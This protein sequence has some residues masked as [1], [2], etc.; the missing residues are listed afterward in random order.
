MAPKTIV[1]KAD[2]FPL[3]K[4]GKATAVA[5]TPGYLLQYDSVAGQIEAHSSSGGNAA[6]LFAI[7][8]ALQGKEIGDNY[9][10]S[11]QVQFVCAR[12]GDEIYAMLK[13]GQ[14][15]TRGQYLESNGDGTLIAYSSGFPVAVALEAV[16]LSASAN[17]ADARIKVEIM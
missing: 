5:I 3:Q 16:D 4:L 2:P 15:I 9:A 11:A 8:D 7:E 1:L 10:V 17:T 12:L 13:D 6:R 14:N